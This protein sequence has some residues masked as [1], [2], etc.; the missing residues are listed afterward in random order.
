VSSF[1]E[2]F[3]P[4]GKQGGRAAV[5]G[6]RQDIVTRG[7]CVPASLSIN[8]LGKALCP[9]ELLLLRSPHSIIHSFLSSL[10]T[11]YLLCRHLKGMR[12]GGGN[13]QLVISQRMLSPLET[14]RNSEYQRRTFVAWQMRH[15]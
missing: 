11:C 4:S 15:Q 8:N 13:N 10:H 2:S 7:T 9:H 14:G 3:K 5:L 6:E 12:G 1:S